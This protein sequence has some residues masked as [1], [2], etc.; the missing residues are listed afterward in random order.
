MANTYTQIHVHFIF[1]VKFRQGLIQK[2]WKDRLYQYIIAIVKNNGHKMLIING[3][4]DHVHSLIG[5]R[6]EQ[7]ISDLMKDVKSNSSKWINEQNFIKGKFPWQEGYGAFTY[8]KSQLPRL[9]SYI[10]NQKEYHTKKT[11][12]EE[13]LK[14]LEE[15]KVEYNPQYLFKDPD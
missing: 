2:E 1:A 5:L 10:E 4:P 8:S 9:I 6:P 7:S 13:Y 12:Q 14:I 11:F 15:Q 3:M